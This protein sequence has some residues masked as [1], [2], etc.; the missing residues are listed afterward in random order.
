MFNEGKNTVVLLNLRSEKRLVLLAG[1]ILN[2]N[3]GG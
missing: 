1:S 2:N 3:E